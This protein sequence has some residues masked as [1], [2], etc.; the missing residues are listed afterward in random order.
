MIGQP[1]WLSV[2]ESSPGS[3]VWLLSGSPTEAVADEYSFDL[4]IMLGTE[5][6]V[7]T[8]QLEVA[9][10]V[11]GD[12]NGDGLVNN[13]DIGAFSLALFS[14]ST[15][16]AMFPATDPD[17]VLDMNNDGAFNNLD[18]AGFAAALGF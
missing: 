3:G 14:R 4:Q 18:I 17:S 13:L 5:A 16:V 7:R 15:Y 1:A 8:V 12:A 11:M 2:K 10:P 6:A 9:A